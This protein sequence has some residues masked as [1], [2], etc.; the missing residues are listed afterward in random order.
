MGRAVALGVALALV[1]ADGAGARERR[2]ECTRTPLEQSVPPPLAR[3]ARA[4]SP[5]WG[6]RVTGLRAG[7]VY[8]VAGSYRTAISRDG[9]TTDSNGRDLHRALVAVSP[10]YTGA[11]TISGRRLGFSTNGAIACSVRRRDVTCDTGRSSLLRFVRELRLPAGT[12]WR[13]VRTELRISG[14]GCFR[15]AISGRGLSGSIPL[16]V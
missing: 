3:A 8:V 2:A 13:I 9:D 12:G 11:I 1:A 6:T 16:S 4:F 10:S 7:P 15:I 5:W 14:T